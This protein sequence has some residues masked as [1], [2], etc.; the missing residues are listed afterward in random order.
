MMFVSAHSR[1]GGVIVIVIVITES[2]FISARAKLYRC[3][4]PAFPFI[5]VYQRK[6]DGMQQPAVTLARHF[7]ESRPNVS[8][9]KGRFCACM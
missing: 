3:R 9:R 4:A 2:D 7:R 5:S 1:C 6:W 8:R